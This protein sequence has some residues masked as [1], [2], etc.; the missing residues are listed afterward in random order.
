MKKERGLLG[1]P[2]PH[3]YSKARTLLLTTV[4]LSQGFSM[5]VFTKVGVDGALSY[6]S[7]PFLLELHVKNRL[8]SDLHKST[9]LR[10]RAQMLACARFSDSIVRTY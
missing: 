8:H 6:C 10:T 2:Q 1:Q 3:I 4:K 9:L 7:L 5:L